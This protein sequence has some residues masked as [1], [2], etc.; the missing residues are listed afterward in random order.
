MLSLPAVATDILIDKTVAKQCVRL[1]CCIEFSALDST[2][3][4]QHNIRDFIGCG[5]ELAI[6]TLI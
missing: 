3:F 5:I 1:Q 4:Y 6:F 2:L